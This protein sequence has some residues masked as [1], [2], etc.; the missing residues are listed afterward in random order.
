MR[1]LRLFLLACILFLSAL[2]FAQTPGK[3]AG[4]DLTGLW[5]AK[6]VSA[7][8]AHVPLIVSRSGDGYR[9]DMLGMDLPLKNESGILTFGVT[10]GEGRFRGRLAKNGDIEGH[11]FRGNAAFPV[12]LAQVHAGR[13][14]GAVTTSPDELTFFLLLK[15]EGENT[16]SAVLRNPERDFGSLYGVTRLARGAQISRPPPPL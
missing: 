1:F 7:G 13:W 2:A 16:W 12:R 11:W 3:S 5:R 15:P 8:L 14:D 6:R 10:N 9:A 4:A